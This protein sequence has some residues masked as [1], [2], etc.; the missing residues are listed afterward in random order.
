MYN[1]AEYTTR[2]ETIAM[3]HHITTLNHAHAPLVLTLD[4]GTSS[5]R[6]LCFDAMMRQVVDVEVRR[7]IDV[8]SN[9]HGAAEIDAPQLMTACVALF[10]EV[11]EVV[12]H[13]AHD[14]VAVAVA[15]MATTMVGV[16][17]DGQPVGP[18]RT[19]ADTQSDASADWLRCHYDERITH[20]RTG[21]LIRPNYWPAR[22]HWIAQHR[23]DE[24]QHARYWMTFAEYFEWQ[25]LG[26]RRIT[27]SNAA[28]TGLLHRETLTWD[29]EWLAILHLDAD[30]LAPVV[31]V[32]VAHCGLRPSWATRWPWLTAVQWFGAIG[33][34]AAAN[35]GS[36]CVDAQSLALT[37]GTTGAMRIAV[38]GHPIPPPG[39]W[40]YRIDRELALVGGATSEG[41]NVYQWMRETLQLGNDEDAIEA[42][43]ARIPPDSH[44]LT[45]VPLWAGE[46]SP[47]WAG[48]AKA[49]IHGMH[50]G[51]TPIELLRAAL[52]SIA[53]RFGLIAQRLPV[54]A[55]VVASGGA[56]LRSPAWLQMCADVLGRPVHTSAV[57]E[58]TA[59]GVAM[60]ALRSMGIITHLSDVPLLLADA[61]EPDSV[62][63]ARYQE[64]LARQHALYTVVV[65][66]SLPT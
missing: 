31:D 37:V 29:K 51:T 17:G 47:G 58:T 59:R 48:A 54:S 25:V 24:W 20:Q 21:C 2:I 27:P 40:C 41:G 28:W 10:D 6:L 56:L 16:D 9:S 45:I 52:E 15:S 49:T 46:R 1:G 14:I 61:Y 57:L 23:P 8:V 35:V 12:A 42:A 22:L 11:T 34:G 30:A 64:A 55:R 44:G 7:T 60:L 53:L 13:R 43:I 5:V 66:D 18:L 36:G 63:H 26:I 4:V 62:A 19:Y 32:D 38:P 3:S 50:L 65:T 33:D 39:L